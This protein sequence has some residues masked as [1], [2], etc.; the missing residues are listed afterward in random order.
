MTIIVVLAIIV[1]MTMIVKMTIFVQKYINWRIKN[2][3]MKKILVTI[4]SYGISQNLFLRKLVREFKS[5]SKYH[6]DIIVHS[7]LDDVGDSYVMKNVSVKKVLLDDYQYLPFSC[8]ETILENKDGYDL[9][10]YT[11]NDILYTERNI[12]AYIKASEVLDGTRF[13]PGFLRFE[14]HNGK[15][16]FPDFHKNY[17]WDP[18]VFYQSQPYMFFH[19]TNE[20]HG[21]I[22][23]T[24]KQLSDISSK[25]DFMS[26]QFADRYKRNTPKVHA[27]TNVYT[28]AGF[29]KVIA[30][31][32]FNDFLL[33]HL[34]NRYDKLGVDNDY[35]QANLIDLIKPKTHVK[36]IDVLRKL[37]SAFGYKSYL[38]IGCDKNQVF[39]Q[40]G[41]KDKT[42][43][44]PVRGGNIRADSDAFFLNNNRKYDIIFID[45]LHERAQV[46]MDIENALKCLNPGGVIVCH[47][48]C[49][50][51]EDMAE[52]PRATKMWTGDCWKAWADLRSSR[53]DLSMLV[54]DADYGIG[55]ITKGN[56]ELL[57]KKEWTYTDFINNKKHI[58]NLIPVSDFFNSK[59]PID[60]KKDFKIQYVIPY[61]LE[62]KIGRAYNESCAIVP[63]EYWIGITDGDIAFL[64]PDWGHTIANTIAANPEYTV[65]TA[66]ASRIGNKQQRYRGVISENPNII[67]HYNIAI[68]ESA[69]NSTRVIPMKECMSGFLMIFPK[70]LWKKIPFPEKSDEGTMLGIDKAWSKKVLAAGY[71]IGIIED[72]YVLHY[73]RLKNGKTDKSHLLC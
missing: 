51:T 26:R 30:I 39:D 23:L 32:H 18:S 41:L 69:K 15:K 52:V 28:E 25:F 59:R 57:E 60:I 14:V 24:R 68:Q 37:I 21:G 7:D 8:R 2:I 56:Q 1:E 44:D 66:Y 33:H 13:I 55:I 67:D 43:V 20:H 71:K 31:S 45:G 53:K 64:N 62:K 58:L 5:F 9:L 22:C 46:L 63:D 65:F 17:R 27:C 48:V 35:M 38:E 40:I 70:W 61:S 36:R 6:V 11:E 49:P 19:F 73:Y 29:V 42:G 34:S 4:A 3:F 16:T 72:Q 47:D 10:I 50:Y 54:V 12:D